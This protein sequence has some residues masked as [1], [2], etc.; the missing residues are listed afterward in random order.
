MGMHELIK[1]L[2]VTIPILHIKN[3]LYLIGHQRMTCDLKNENLMLRVGGGFEKFIDYVPKNHRYIERSLVVHMI[4]SGESL[5][6]VVDALFNGRKLKNLIKE[7]NQEIEEPS[8]PGSKKSLKRK[9]STGDIESKRAR[10]AKRSASRNRPRFSFRDV[11]PY[12]KTKTINIQKVKRP[13]NAAN[14]AWDDQENNA[15]GRHPRQGWARIS[16][17]F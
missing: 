16:M 13:N 7:S 3:K 10:S 8:T 12:S 14:Y 5:E 17:S 11:D 4:K 2:T 15:N 1:D 6:G 9:I